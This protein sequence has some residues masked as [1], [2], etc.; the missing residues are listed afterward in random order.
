MRTIA[1][2]TQALRRRGVVN[3]KGNV[4]EFVMTAINHRICHE[5]QNK[6]IVPV[7]RGPLYPVLILSRYGHTIL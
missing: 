2:A 7:S 6:R 1:Q 3:I 5:I 4:W